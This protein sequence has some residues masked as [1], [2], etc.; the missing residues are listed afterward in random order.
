[1]WCVFLFCS[2]GKI[3]SFFLILTYCNSLVVNGCTNG[4]IE[5][6]LLKRRAEKIDGLSMN[7]GSGLDRDLRLLA[8]ESFNG[9]GTMNGLLL[10]GTIMEKTEM[11]DEYPEIQIWRNT[12]SNIYTRQGREEIKLSPGDF[13]P[14]GVFQYNLTNS[15]AFESGDVL[16]VYQP[17]QQDSVVR[18]YYDSI[19]LL[20]L[21]E[22]VEVIHQQHLYLQR[23]SKLL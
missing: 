12:H 14:D 22:S 1:M 4:F 19:V 11:R 15:I 21:M 18:V 8:Q 2:K 20:L 3:F 23:T 5:L 7:T 17:S 16:G 10:A 6:D 13:S 9:S